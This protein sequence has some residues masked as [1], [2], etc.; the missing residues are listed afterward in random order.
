MTGP[1]LLSYFSFWFIL[2]CLKLTFYVIFYFF[3]AT[4]ISNT[5]QRETI[6]SLLLGHPYG[7]IS[8]RKKARINETIVEEIGTH[9]RDLARNLK[10][11]EC[12]IDEIDKQKNTL[13]EKAIE[14]LKLYEYKADPQRGFY[15]LCSALEKTRRKDLSRKIQEIMVMNM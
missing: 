5:P 7:N 15:V 4:D 8:T 2:Y 11:Q 1:S 6:D 14:L 3:S 12:R 13:E 10:M 9:W